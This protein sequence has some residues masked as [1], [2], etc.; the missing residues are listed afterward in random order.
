M[1]RVK[2]TKINI[3]VVHLLN[4]EIACVTSN[5]ELALHHITKTQKDPIVFWQYGVMWILYFDVKHAISLI[6]KRTT[7][8]LILAISDAS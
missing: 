7:E 1:S 3:F 4:R 2:V 6:W 8:I 5:T